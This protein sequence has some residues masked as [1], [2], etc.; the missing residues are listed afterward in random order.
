M[1]ALLMFGSLPSHI[2]ITGGLVTIAGVAL[3]MKSR[4]K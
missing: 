4:K 2:Q 1:G 3:M